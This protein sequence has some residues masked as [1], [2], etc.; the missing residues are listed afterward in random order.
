MTD[1]DFIFWMAEELRRVAEPVRT[2][3]R[4][5]QDFV[6]FL[7]RYGWSPPPGSF[8]IGD[9]RNAF[10]V[11]EEMGICT[12]L[13][14]GL[15][16]PSSDEESL[17]T[18]LALADV[19]RRI[20]DKLRGLPRRQRP[21]GLTEELWTSFGEDLLHGLVADY[22]ETYRP[23]LLAPL[24]LTGV[25][26]EQLV[27][28]G[29]TPDRIPY[30]RRR[31][32]W[33][34]LWPALTD[35]RGLSRELYGWN[36]PGRPLRFELLVE[37]LHRALNLLGLPTVL[38]EPSAALVPLYFN[39]ANPAIPRLQQ[40]G[41]LLMGGED[42]RGELVQ[43]TLGVLP[44]P[45]VGH[46]AQAPDGLL[47]APSFFLGTQPSALLWPFSL[48]FS[49]IFQNE[50]GVRVE[51]EPGRAAVAGRAA[52]TTTVDAGFAIVFDSPNAVLL[53][54]TAF[55]HHLQLHGWRLGVRV[56]GPVDDLELSVE[57]ELTGIEFVLTLAEGD[58]LVRELLG[59]G[60]RTMTF[61]LAVVWS[62]R[63]G[64]HFRGQGALELV[65]PLHLT[66]GAVR[67]EFLTIKLRAEDERNALTA[68]LTGS[69]R[70]GPLA[71]AVSNVGIRF[72]LT[73][74]PAE[75]PA[76][77]LGDLDV[78]LAFKPPD[79]IGLS[80]EAGVVTGAGFLRFGPD[81]GRYSG[82][83]VVKIADVGVEAVGL[84]ETRLPGAAAGYS[85]LVLMRGEFPPV[86]VGFG[87][88]L[89]AVG[90]LLALNRRVDVDALRNRLAAGTAGRILAPEDPIRNAP[91]LL[92]DLA[93]VFPV[94]VGV[95]VVG[96]TVH[97]VWVGLV[98]F[99]L[100]IFVE[101][102]GPERVVILGSARALIDKPDGGRPYLIIRVDV[103]GV[104]DLQARTAAF[105]AVLI[106]SQ[107]LEILDLTG[108]AAFRLSWGA[109]PYSVL[110]VGGFHPAYNPEPLAFPSSLSR[111][112]MVHGDPSDTLYLRFEGYFAVTTNTFQFGAAVEAV[113]NS[114][115][116]NIQGI[117]RFDALIRFQPFHFQFDIHASVRLRYKSRNLAGLSLSGELSGPGPVIFRGKVCIEILFFD[118]CFEETFTLGSS[119][120]P[121]VTPVPSAVAALAG[122]LDEPANLRVSETVDRYVAV[123]PPPADLG[124][125][126]VSPLGQLVWVQQRAPLN[127]LLQR[128]GGAPLDA[129]ELV[130]A[131]SPQ[132][133]GA[134][135]DWF[136]PGSFAELTDAEAL[137][138]RG[139]E[140]LTGGLRF[141]MPGTDDGPAADKD[142]IVRQIRL[143]AK[144]T[145]EVFATTFPAW[146]TAATFSR[147]GGVIDEP[148]KP[149]V[150][151]HEETWTVVDPAGG[152][153]AADLSGAQAHQLAALGPAGVAVA[154]A[155]RI[156]AFTF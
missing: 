122:E 68:G 57:L 114:G 88:A 16:S 146:L 152:T 107:L 28:S 93:T 94:A 40:L 141:G 46:P 119:H 108:G 25:I 132:L 20:A 98:H 22:L 135:L 34:R 73:P 47:L 118:I 86:Q 89:T 1:R 71:V 24:I 3:M 42:E 41:V 127:L 60:T 5:P 100:G 136:A 74:V 148:V 102:P 49:G 63:S 32:R 97:L 109:Q 45:P 87:F 70:L 140:R 79:G 51:L 56:S 67:I 104:V 15:L 10:D 65:V 110:T 115:N 139:F 144:A 27:D 52:D 53:F 18:Y 61:D 11:L 21:A 92:A 129:P 85:L 58:S 6:T 12:R 121:T 151:M 99:D 19:V 105:D 133:A 156:P 23:L 38:A 120:P 43:Y 50:G 153:L 117:L 83:L 36:D 82:E 64:L 59:D 13:V 147:V 113:I 128:I 149:S 37:R 81:N 55:S 91:S 112:A 7:E 95:T 96:P 123:R 8:Q 72:L 126:V 33:E 30:V 35:P 134:E 111:I 62:S 44:I 124:P 150:T 154:T 142:V 66:I 106:D 9:V 39:A 101:L 2:A 54:G 14:A 29:G 90:G 4:T 78:D 103:V 130:Q 31:I 131:A 116:F 143:P 138:R 155:D 76:G 80:I 26:E 75:S 137:N 48:E 125:P 84:V 145:A 69:A 77:V 17:D